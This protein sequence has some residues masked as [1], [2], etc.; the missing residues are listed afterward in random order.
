[1]Y[2]KVQKSEVK[3]ASDLSIDLVSKVN[4]TIELNGE[5]KYVGVSIQPRDIALVTRI[6]KK[7][8][9]K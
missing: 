8:L 5:G 7:H 3:S 6:I 4:G 1:M 9:R 2:I